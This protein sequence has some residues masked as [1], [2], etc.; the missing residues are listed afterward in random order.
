MSTKNNWNKLINTLYKILDYKNL[1]N[2]LYVSGGLVPYLCANRKSERIHDDIDFIVNIKDIQSVRTYI[3][4][5]NCYNPEYDSLMFKNSKYGDYGF[6]VNFLGVN[7]SFSPFEILDNS[8]IVQYV[9]NRKLNLKKAIM[10]G[11]STKDYLSKINFLGRNIKINSLEFM[12]A[13]KEI[14]YREKDIIDIAIIDNQGYNKAKYKRIKKSLTTMQEIKTKVNQK[15]LF[16]QDRVRFS[17]TDKCNLSC[18]YCHNEGQGHSCNVNNLSLDYIKD[19][20]NFVKNNDVY[21]SKINITGGEPLLH[22]DVLEIIKILS[23]V[24]KKIKLNTNG[25]L[26]NKEIILKLKECGLTDMNVG[27]DSFINVQSKPNLYK[28]NYDIEILKQNVLFAKDYFN[29]SL[30]TVVTDYNYKQI[31]DII[32]FSRNNGL[33]KIK[34]IE[35]IDYDFWKNNKTNAKNSEFFDILLDKY[36]KQAKLVEHYKELGK[37]DITLSDG[38]MIRFGQDFCKTRCCGSLYSIINAKGEYVCCQKSNDSVKLDFKEPYKLVEET[39]LKAHNTIC[40]NTSN[41]YPRDN[42]GNVLINKW[43]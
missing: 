8:T 25:T 1:S 4:E 17:L 21:I 31:E 41:D 11:M 9:L 19:F 20:V 33:K 10:K 12:K 32:N 36:I 23:N 2:I 26:L 18:Y 35:L 34:L 3:K 24:C 5:L 14:P 37:Y 15:R 28:F 38:F 39:L 30:N 27:I 43:Q 16:I 29:V 13:I 6:K 22:K 42:N 40:K 7:L